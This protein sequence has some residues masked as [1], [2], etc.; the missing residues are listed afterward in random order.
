MAQTKTLAQYQAASGNEITLSFDSIRNLISDNPDVTDKECMTFAALCKSHKLD[1]FI[2]E[3]YIVKFGSK[4]AQMIVGKD[5]W[6]KQAGA[7]PQFDGMEAGVVVKTKEGG[8]ERR[9][10]SLVG[11]TTERLVGGWAKV[12]RKDRRIPSYAEVALSEY[13]T[14]RSMWKAANQGGKP[15]T[16][17]RK[18]AVVQALREAFPETFSGLY[19]S[20]EMGLDNEPGAEPV[21]AEVEAAQ[22]AQEPEYIEPDTDQSWAPVQGNEEAYAAYEA[23]MADE[24]SF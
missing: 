3:A 13:S 22:P 14:G 19:D 6:M 21:R 20:S 2:R 10:G 9:Q 24:G 15:A 11:S 8:L 17:I 4:P 12:Y 16:M 18:T 7:H 1:P 5:Y 23:D